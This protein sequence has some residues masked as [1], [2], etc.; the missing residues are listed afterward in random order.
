MSENKFHWWHLFAPSPPPCHCTWGLR[1]CVYMT[2]GWLFDN[3]RGWCLI[4][5]NV[6]LRTVISTPSLHNSRVM[7]VIVADQDIIM[8]HLK[9]PH[10]TLKIFTNL[11]HSAS[12]E[13]SEPVAECTSAVCRDQLRVSVCDES[14]DQ[15][16]PVTL[17]LPTLTHHQWQYLRRWNTCQP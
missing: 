3:I 9:R 2:V 13:S 17:T 10:T 8:C 7:M 16:H 15:Q 11:C 4:W 14:W 12:W 1:Y 6:Y 5:H